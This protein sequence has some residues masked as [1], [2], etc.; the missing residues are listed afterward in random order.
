MPELMGD[1]SGWW[2]LASVLWYSVSSRLDDKKVQ[3]T[4]YVCE[5]LPFTSSSV[6]TM[7]MMLIKKWFPKMPT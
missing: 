5:T 4:K 3:L 2:E 6:N 7:Q 1:S